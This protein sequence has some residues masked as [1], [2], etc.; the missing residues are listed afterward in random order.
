MRNLRSSCSSKSQP[1]VGPHQELKTHRKTQRYSQDK[2]FYVKPMILMW[3]KI[4]IGTFKTE[5]RNY[6]M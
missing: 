3:F 5:T 6:F 1:K 2:K 4:L